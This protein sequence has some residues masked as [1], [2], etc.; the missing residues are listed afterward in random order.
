MVKKEIASKS[1]IAKRRKLRGRRTQ[2]RD[3]MPKKDELVAKDES[4]EDVG[5]ETSE[6]RG[7]KRTKLARVKFA[8][9]EPHEDVDEE[10]PRKRGPKKTGSAKEKLAE[11]SAGARRKLA[12]ISAETKKKL[13][14]ASS[15]KRIVYGLLACGV[16]VLGAAIGYSYWPIQSAHAWS[17]TQKPS[18]EKSSPLSGLK[19]L[20]PTR[21]NL[22][23]LIPTRQNLKNAIPTH[24][25]TG[26]FENNYH[27]L[28][29]LASAVGLILAAFLFTEGL[30]YLIRQ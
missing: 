13:V 23:N 2:K 3:K 7:P 19:N 26:F 30:S 17:F 4:Y 24:H 11:I 15:D 14:E 27:F 12:D 6:T 5:E 1:R 9:E 21:Q 22:K 8:K 29:N 10:K 28:I 18:H 16:L 20:I 25:G